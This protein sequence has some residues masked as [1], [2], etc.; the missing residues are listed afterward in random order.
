MF[1]KFLRFF[2]IMFCSFKTRI[3]VFTRS[4]KVLK[5]YYVHVK[6]A[7]IFRQKYMLATEEYFNVTL[8]SKYFSD[9][10]KNYLRI[11]FKIKVVLNN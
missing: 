2:A 4:S 6:I 9:T 3:S 10:C 1:L 5:R 7:I 8:N 11:Q